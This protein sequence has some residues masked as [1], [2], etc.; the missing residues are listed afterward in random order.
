MLPSVRPTQVGFLL[1][2][3]ASMF[4]LGCGEHAPDPWEGAVGKKIMV[5]F[6][7]LHS[8]VSN[9]AGEHAT[10]KV[11]LD[12]TGVHDYQA[13]PRDAGKLH[14]AD[15]F[16]Y[17]GLELDDTFAVALLRNSANPG[18]KERTYAVGKAI[19]QDR[20]LK[21][22]EHEHVHDAKDGGACAGC[23][24]KH[25]EF[26]PHIWLGVPEAI[27]MV[28]YIRDRLKEN[29]PSHAADYDTNAAR[30]IEKLRKLHADGLAK[31]TSKQNKKFV[32][33]HESLSYFARCFHVEAM[34]PLQRLPGEDPSS[35]R[36]QDIVKRCQQENVRVI[37]V[38]PGQIVNNTGKVLLNEL[39]VKGVADP[40]IVE[41]D[42]LESA[43]A[44]EL[45]PDFYERKLAE[46][47]DKL[48][49]ALR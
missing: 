36:M 18:L 32:P 7:P 44:N 6:P 42:V 29:D 43:S 41:I 31:F 35:A 28:E 24:H 22:A 33:S 16:F 45:K 11:L 9:V 30:Y 17:N 37:A 13:S 49:Q 14:K 1:A 34:K 39:K 47:I 20:L 12:N 25:G 5:S 46:N 21:M 15:I 38:E 8:F 40:Q 23:G 19:P 3:L 26:D 4:A 10:V 48:A 2:A 27:L